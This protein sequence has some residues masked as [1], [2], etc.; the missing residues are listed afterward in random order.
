MIA[1]LSQSK[2]SVFDEIDLYLVA[3][4]KW[5][6]ANGYAR[7]HNGYGKT[8]VLMHREILKARKGQVV[9]HINGDKLDNRRCNLRIC[10]ISENGQNSTLP[11]NNI[12][13]YKGVSWH[14][15]KNKWIA[16]VMK[17][18]KQ[19]FLGYFE[20][21]QEAAH[22]YNEGATLLHGEFARINYNL[23]QKS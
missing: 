5:H 12:S 13:G 20:T 10:T 9:D 8:C 2:V 6:Y 15:V 16:Q 23:C 17:E 18:G 7:R 11:I 19:Y 4:H 1:L 14:K 22:A 21:A 3:K